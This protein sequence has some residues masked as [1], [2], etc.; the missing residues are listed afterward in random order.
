MLHAGL[1]DDPFVFDLAQFNRILC[2]TQDVFRAVSSSPLGPLRGRSVR[3][4]GT[5]GV[6]SFAGFNASYIVVEF[7]VSW[8]GVNKTIN[9]WG[10]VSA[11]SGESNG[12]IQFERMGQPAFSTIFMPKPLKDAFNQ[13]IP[14]DDLIRWSQFVPDALTTTDNDGTGNTV[15]GRAGLLTALGLTTAPTGAPLLLPATYLPQHQQG[16]V[17][18]CAVA[19]CPAVRS[20][21]RSPAR[22]G[23]WCKRHDQLPAS[24][25]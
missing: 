3:A 19:R 16:F 20:E 25:R 15:S 5:S 18:E 9:V 7:P 14:S 4:D 17:A 23:D 10:T 24:R 11:P 12:F 22:S 1:R 13:G 6:D 21:P 8:L 2:G